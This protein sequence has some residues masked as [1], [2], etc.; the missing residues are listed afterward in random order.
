MPEE[1]TLEDIDE[2]SKLGIL[3]QKMSSRA[4]EITK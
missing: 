1:I 2:E 3:I 4:H